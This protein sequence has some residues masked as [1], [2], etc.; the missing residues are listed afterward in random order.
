MFNITD[1]Q[2]ISSNVIVESLDINTIKS[3]EATETVL[4]KYLY[5]RNNSEQL[6]LKKVTLA[7]AQ[8]LIYVLEDQCQVS[9][10]K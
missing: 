8:D 5:K 4:F 3:D 1:A 9:D 2:I 6:N 7:L 10:Q